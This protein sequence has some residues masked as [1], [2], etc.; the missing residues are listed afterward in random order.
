LGTGGPPSKSPPSPPEA[1]AVVPHFYRSPDEFVAAAQ[2]AVAAAAPRQPVAILIV[3]VD[4]ADASGAVLPAAESAIG[5]VAE[6]VRHTA[7][8]DDMVG[9]I[10]NR[11]VMVLP[12]S[13][14]EDGRAA[15]ERLCAAVRIHSFGEG[16]GQLTLSAGAAAA[17]EH[18][19]S[20]DLVFDWAM[21]ALKR[22]QSQG[23]DGAGAAPLPHHEALHRPLSI[24]RFAGRA[25]ELAQLT[26]WLDD[27]S[28]SQPRVV[29]VIGETGTG[30]A[31]L[32]HQLEPEVRLRGGIFVTVSSPDLAVRKPYGAWQAFLRVTHRFPTAPDREWHEL[33]HLERSLRAPEQNGNTGS[34]YR[35]LGEL[36]EYVRA[37]ASNRL[38]VIV[39]DEM[40]WAD[41]TTWDALEHLLTQL[42]TDRMMICLAQR[43]DSAYESSP[44]RQML[45]RFDISRDLTIS[46]LT[47]DEV[48]QWL[49]AAFHRQ[50]VAREFLAFL[51]RHTEGNPLFVHQLL[52][53]LVE[54]GAIWYNGSRW[55]WSPVSELRLPAGRRA[56]ISQ[57]IA[58]FSSSTQAVLG[59]AAIVGREFDVGLLVGAG[60]GSEPAVRLAISEAITSGLLRPT[61]ERKQGGFAF[62]HDE[63]AEVLVESI[64]RTQIAQLHSRVAGSLEKRRPDRLGEIALHFDAAGESEDAYRAGQTAAKAAERVY[65]HHAAGA[66]LQLAARNAT[67]PAELAEIRVALAHNAET[68]GRFDEVEELCDLAIEWF[69]GQGDENRALTLRRMRE[70]ARMELGQPAKVSLDSLTSLD[71][72]ARALGNDGER[73][74]LMMMISQTHARLGDHETASAIAEDCVRMAE[75]VGD[76]VLLAAAEMRLGGSLLSPK[77]GKARVWYEKA[78]Q[79]FEELGDVR[80]QARAYNNIGIS[81]QFEA[82]LDAA[83][84]AF[85]RAINV[86]RAGG[87]PDVWGLA[88]LNL[89]VLFQ[90]RGDYDRARELLGEALALFAAVKH[91][92][93][94]LGAL[95]NMAN[96]ERE[97]GLWESAAELYDATIPLA[98]RVGHFEIEMGAT[99]GSGLCFLELGRVT[100]A[101]AAHETVVS[102]IGGRET[103]FQSREIAD[104]LMVR[105]AV[106]DGRFQDALSHFDVALRMAEAADLYN[107][108]WLLAICAESLLAVDPERVK[109]TVRE[110]SRRVQSLGYPE[111]T[112]RY[113]ALT[114]R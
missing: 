7:R 36:T 23:R 24:D 91:S 53:T 12:G 90:K 74:A 65:A 43:P 72:D 4:P 89:G 30:T 75:E 32:L 93:F 114:G 64:P 86:S 109:L 42:D 98:Q 14:A 106:A 82:H 8:E 71:A 11:L 22:I 104:A 9:R 35:L 110:Y 96:V 37:L 60:A 80:G 69:E 73:L 16:L 79:I 105:M 49:E 100:E 61:Y 56:L 5:A 18:S 39:L 13:T 58:R 27:A 59:T 3:E 102:R 85:I 19:M 38:L 10:D 47:R 67:T 63:I 70:R 48:K 2:A 108:A 44:H 20:Y 45:Q 41:G 46:R 66:Y 94:Q 15:G 95:Y 29:T 111:M 1:P 78:L 76:K 31:S 83:T 6:I 103:W 97:L 25:Q 51:Y 101:R 99:A 87:M 33:Q 113:E 54:D 62:V 112:R 107:A 88:A 77:P 28:N 68:G 92:E 84:E 26:T 50:V 40:Q 17:P 55:E 81:E 34:Q 57:R 21:R 52:R